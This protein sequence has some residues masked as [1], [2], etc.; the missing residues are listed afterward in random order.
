MKGLKPEALA[1][2][3]T[4]TPATLGATWELVGFDPGAV[5]GYDGFDWIARVQEAPTWRVIPN[6]GRDGWSLG[7]WPLVAV[8]HGCPEADDPAPYRLIER[9]E[10]D[11]EVWAFET[12]EALYAATDTL[13]R[14]HWERTPEAH[15][16]AVADAIKATPEGT[17]LPARFRGPFSWSRLREET[18]SADVARDDRQ[19]VTT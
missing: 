11:L 8:A 7:D 4:I 16:E 9:I 19:E 5:L 1:N 12:Q 17:P 13:A 2:P 3:R 6:Y 10:G 14:R 18:E 15:G